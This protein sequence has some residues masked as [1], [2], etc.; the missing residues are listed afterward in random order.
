MRKKQCFSDQIEF[1]LCVHGKM[2][3]AKFIIQ[4]FNWIQTMKKRRKF[5]ASLFAVARKSSIAWYIELILN[6]Y[7]WSRQ[8]DRSNRFF[9]IAAQRKSDPV[10]IGR[11]SSAVMTSHVN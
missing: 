7:F 6:D 9:Q 5:Y 2:P 10:S 3:R 11:Y 4:L 8:I 1:F